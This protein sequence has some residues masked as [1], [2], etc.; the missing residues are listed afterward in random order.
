MSIS[1][2]AS[3]GASSIEEDRDRVRAFVGS[4]PGHS[5]REVADALGLTPRHALTSLVYL[6]RQELVDRWWD[7]EVTRWFPPG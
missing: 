3:R 1:S 4:W 2:P 6:E 7:G 5:T